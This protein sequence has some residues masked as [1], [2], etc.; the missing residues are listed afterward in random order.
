VPLFEP[1]FQALNDA[2]AR[3]VV[4]GGVATVLHGFARFTADVDLI[5][6]LSPT[7]AEKVLNCLTG[8]GFEP[9]APVLASDFA[10]PAKR[11]E[12]MREKNMQVFSMLDPNDPMRAV[13]L[14]VENPI[15]FEELWSRSELVELVATSVRIAS[16]ADLIELKRIAGRPQDLADIEQLEKIAA[17]ERDAK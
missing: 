2:E 13:D 1:L 12:W 5:I 14:F 4:V 16:V 17:Q 9:R 3:Y 10:D 8:L 11:G 15:D 7:E 6:D